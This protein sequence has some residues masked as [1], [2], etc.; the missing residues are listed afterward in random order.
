MNTYADKKRSAPQP[1]QTV[2][3]R[4]QIQPKLDAMRNVDIHS[5]HSLQLE[6]GLK[7]RIEQHLGYDLSGV[8][9]R[10]SR[11]AAN[12]GAEAFAKGNVV[13]FA[14]GRFD[15]HS[16][17]GQHLIAHEL[18][19]VVQQA[20]GGVHADVDGFN[21]NASSAFESAADH[22][23]D[24][25][26]SGGHSALSAPLASLPTMN[27]DAAP[28][29][30]SFVDSIRNFFGK[31]KEMEISGPTNVNEFGYDPELTDE[32]RSKMRNT[33]TADIAN[34]KM[35]KN[36]TPAYME[37][38]NDNDFR[39]L[40]EMIGGRVAQATAHD[41]HAAGSKAGK[42]VPMRENFTALKNQ[43]ALQNKY[44]EMNGAAKE[45]KRWVDGCTKSSN[46]ELARSRVL[47]IAKDGAN[48][49]KVK[50]LLQQTFA[51]Y[52]ADDGFS[53]DDVAS[54]AFNH[55]VLRSITPTEIKKDEYQSNL[56]KDIMRMV[57]DS[58]DSLDATSKALAAELHSNTGLEDMETG[59]GT[60]LRATGS[61]ANTNNLPKSK[62]PA[63][64]AKKWWQFWK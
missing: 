47:Q 61:V 35:L 56:R 36:L 40:N 21:V 12:M 18:S 44:T 14:P 23:G 63:A 15:Q 58:T 13:H 57:G 1:R 28:I 52:S 46:Q 31:K 39:L 17:Q 32:E 45:Y 42:K 10:E 8:E 6:D 38:L 16:T 5:G 4:E 55:Y 37:K 25:F 26:V 64:P 60:A 59:A 9:L 20:K 53:K 54:L 22:A 29:Q 19:H 11:D 33:T 34:Y 48:D 51:N 41:Y 2:P 49:P 30:G 27:A 7:S 43:V 3:N 50:D 62:A 24:S